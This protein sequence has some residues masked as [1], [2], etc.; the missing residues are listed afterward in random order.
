M[1]GQQ[2]P[3]AVHRIGRK[4]SAVERSQV[5]KLRL[6]VLQ[7][8]LEA[9]DPVPDEKAGELVLHFEARVHQRF[10]A[11][12]GLAQ[13]LLFFARNRGHRAAPG[14]P[15]SQPI[16]VVSRRATSRRSVL[17]RLP[18]RSTAMLAACMT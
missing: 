4:R 8:R 3:E 1:L 14:S 6:G 13:V 17:A 7:P 12:T 2:K 11:A 18:R 9:F 15:R 10:P 16:S 5:A